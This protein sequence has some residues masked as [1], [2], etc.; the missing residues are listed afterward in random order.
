MSKGV[1]HVKDKH[2]VVGAEERCSPTADILGCAVATQ[3]LYGIT[4]GHPLHSDTTIFGN[5]PHT[6]Q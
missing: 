6:P 4:P 1:I 3:D 5:Y 2:V